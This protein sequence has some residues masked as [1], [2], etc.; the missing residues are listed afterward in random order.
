LNELPS[1]EAM[2]LIIEKLEQDKDKRGI[3]NEYE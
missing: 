2:Q 3:F 1:D